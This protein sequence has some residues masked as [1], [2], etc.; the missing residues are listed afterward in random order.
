MWK[1]LT[2]AQTQ[3]SFDVILCVLRFMRKE[4]I[5]RLV[6]KIKK[7]TAQ[8]HTWIQK[9][10]WFTFSRWRFFLS[11]WS[12]NIGKLCANDGWWMGDTTARKKS[13]HI[14]ATQGMTKADLN[15]E[16]SQID[17]IPIFATQ[18]WMIWGGNFWFFREFSFR[19]F[20][21][22]KLPLFANKCELIDFF[23]SPVFMPLLSV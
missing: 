12:I 6:E 18:W 13:S 17:S 9:G 4:Q 2:V 14:H 11:S 7:K 16:E 23:P 5:L 21:K 20:P 22:K 1:I 19:N 8:S 15:C 10:S 3:S